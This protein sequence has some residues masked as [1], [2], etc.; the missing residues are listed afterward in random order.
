MRRAYNQTSELAIK[1]WC[2]SRLETMRGYRVSWWAHWAQLAEMFLPRRYRWFVTPNQYNRGGP[3]NQSIIDETGV[4]AARILYTGM[5]AGLTDPTSPWFA[6]GIAG[7]DELDEGP[8]KTW[9]AT[10]TDRMLQVIGGSN[11]YQS[12][13]QGHHDN[14]VFGSSP[15]II[16]EHPERVI[17]C[18]VPCAGE[19]FF[20]LDNF[21]EVDTLYR[22]YSYTIAELKKE[23]GEENLSESSK[24][25]ARNASAQDTEVVVCHAV[26]PNGDVFLGGALAPPIVPASFKFREIYWEQS[27][28]A[29]GQQRGFHLLRAKG[30]HEQPFGALRW[31]VTSNDPYGRSPGMDALPATRQLQLEQ[32][33]KGEGIDKMVRP[34]MVGSMGLKNEPMSTLPGGITFVSNPQAEGFKPAYTVE[35][36]IQ[37][38]MEDIKEVQARI[39]RIFFNDLFMNIS[40]LQT[41]RSATEIEARNSETLIQIGPVIERT[42]GEL[43]KMI[44]RIYAIMARRK[45]FPPPPPE[46]A[47]KA[48]SINY[49]SMFAQLQRAASTAIIE[50]FANFAG[51]LAGSIS[52]EIW[53]NVDSDEMLDEYADRLNVPPKL[54][55]AAKAVASIRANRAQAQQ[56][57]AALQTGSAAAQGAATLSKAD[58]GGGQN[59]LQAVLGQRAAA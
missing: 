53:D 32:R 3:L 45:L 11:F 48:L 6:L 27:S 46:L 57:Q 59:A 30:F 39:Q 56:A 49:V 1:A 8:A 19:Y 50:R 34:P 23:F 54:L 20:G 10:C 31:D 21:L 51:T 24:Q 42:E 25:M 7:E 43:D 47:G 58:V 15:L 36:R 4:V 33:R 38:M 13:G 40:Q 26:E 52:P 55:R 2:T 35:P 12:L 41:V 18:Y 44:K 37:E 9:L 29:G 22:E 17:S 28:Q 14:V 16:Y 5:L